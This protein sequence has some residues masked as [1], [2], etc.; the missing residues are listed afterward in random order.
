[1]TK[2]SE[3]QRFGKSTANALNG[4]S[5]AV[6]TELHV[7]YHLLAAIVVIVLGIITP[8]TRNEWMIIGMLVGSV[9]TAA[10][11][12]TAI[13]KLTDLVSPDKHPQAGLVKDLAA[14]AVLVIAIVAAFVG[15]F[16]FIPKYIAL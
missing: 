6:K 13:E 10:L 7:R 2:K 1:M 3:L 12:N 11:F 8:I 16:I 15:A 9:L 14:G 5:Q 4:L